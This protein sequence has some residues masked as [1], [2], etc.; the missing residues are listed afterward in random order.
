MTIE[1]LVMV[2]TGVMIMREVLD[3][4]GLYS[5]RRAIRV[6]KAHMS[7]RGL[8][9]NGSG[10]TAELDRVRPSR[11]N[12]SRSAAM[13]GGVSRR[14]RRMAGGLGRLDELK[15]FSDPWLLSVVKD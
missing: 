8:L 3:I 11:D 12:G 2:W 9:N 14:R 5:P 10:N 4:Q 6:S 15:F 13:L 7:R 1:V